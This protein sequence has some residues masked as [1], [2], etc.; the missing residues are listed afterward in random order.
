MRAGVVAAARLELGPGV[1]EDDG[2]SRHRPDLRVGEPAA[3]LARR[4]DGPDLRLRRHAVGQSPLCAGL[5]RR[6]AHLSA[7][8]Q[9]GPASFCLAAPA[10]YH[11]QFWPAIAFWPA[12]AIN[13]LQYGSPSDDDAGQSSDISVTNPQQLVVAVGW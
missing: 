7:R 4:F 6:V 8:E 1:V 13:N 12:N 10:N 3:D 5:N 9:S 11:A 2:S